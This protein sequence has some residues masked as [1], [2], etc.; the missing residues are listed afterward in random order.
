[1][2]FQEFEGR[3]K[4][5]SLWGLL[6]RNSCVHKNAIVRLTRLHQAGFSVFASTAIC[7]HIEA[8]VTTT[9]IYLAQEV[10]DHYHCFSCQVFVWL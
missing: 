3:A 8:G 1:M 5:S 6:K 4:F 7:V 2:E 9:F 10:V